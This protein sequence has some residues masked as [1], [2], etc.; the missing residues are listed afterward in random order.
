MPQQNLGRI[1]PV[2]KGVWNTTVSYVH[3]DIVTYNGSSYICKVS[4]TNQLP[5]VSQYWGLLADKGDTGEAGGMHVDLSNNTAVGDTA[6][7]R[8][9]IGDLGYYGLHGFNRNNDA[10]VV[11]DNT[12]TDITNLD[13]ITH[14]SEYNIETSK[15]N[16]PIGSGWV[17]CK[18]MVHGYS[19]Q[20]ITQIVYKMQGNNSNDPV[21]IRYK[22][23][24]TWED[25]IVIPQIN[26]LTGTIAYSAAANPLPGWL[27]ANGAVV[28]RTTYANL[29]AVIGTT[30]GSGDGSTT[31]NLPDLRGEFIRC[32]DNG[33]GVNSGR[34]FGTF[35]NYD[36]KSFSMTT[37]SQNTYSYSHGPVYMGKSTSHYTGNLFAGH[38]R[39]PAAA[40]GAQWDTSEIRPRNI[41]L[42]ACIKY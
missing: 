39:E 15:N 37:T 32:W 5:T 7:D 38:W 29:F 6:I 34:G 30:F 25:W 8:L 16:S 2:H 11:I 35:E 18:T 1:I 41:A 36:W 17:F 22:T 28:S 3:L 12:R 40:I 23:A 21:A 19:N 9:G 26:N 24:G 14:N 31:F 27:R 13:D 20:Y 33:R 4:N 42:L 10:H